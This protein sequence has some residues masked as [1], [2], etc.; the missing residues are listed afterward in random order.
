MFFVQIEARCAGDK[1]IAK[2]KNLADEVGGVV[3][4][5]GGHATITGKALTKEEAD[6]LTDFAEEY[7]FH[8]IFV[9]GTEE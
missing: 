7:P 8:S 1:D 9:Q 3:S 4:Y 5:Q 2:W 6:R